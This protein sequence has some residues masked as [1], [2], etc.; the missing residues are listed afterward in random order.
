MEIPVQVVSGDVCRIIAASGTA[1]RLPLDRR[2]DAFFAA[3][4]QDTLI[5]HSD[6]MLP[7]QLIP[8]PPVSHVRMLFMDIL[9]L[10]R[11]LFIILFAETDR[12]F[13]PAIVS[14]A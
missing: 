7:V 11:D 3:D 1:L 4:P 8:Y 13:Q 9:D 10:L 5:I 6:T 2:L 12:A 14:A